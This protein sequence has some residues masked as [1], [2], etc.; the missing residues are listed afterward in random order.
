MPPAGHWN[1]LRRDTRGG[2]LSVGRPSGLLP[3]EAARKEATALIMRR[4]AVS[5]EVSDVLEGPPLPGQPPPALAASLGDG[6]AQSGVRLR[7]GRDDILLV[8]GSKSHGH[9]VDRDSWRGRSR[10]LYTGGAWREIF[11]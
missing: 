1:P 3:D 2:A 5:E 10:Y 4:A 6:E 7:R 11:L 9:R 8:V